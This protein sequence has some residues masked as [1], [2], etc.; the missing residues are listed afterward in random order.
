M[1]QKC[2]LENCTSTAIKSQLSSEDATAITFNYDVGMC[3]VF[4]N[5][6]LIE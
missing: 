4:S 1:S 6:T 3:L 5:N 2:N